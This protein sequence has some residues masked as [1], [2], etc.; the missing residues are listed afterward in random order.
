MAALMGPIDMSAIQSGRMPDH[1]GLGRPV[2]ARVSLH[3]VD[4]GSSHRRAR[5]MA[6][7]LND[8][9]WVN[10]RSADAILYSAEE[11]VKDR[12]EEE[13]EEGDAKHAGEHGDAHG[14]T[15]LGAD[16]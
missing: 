16:A 4:L 1:W 14:V 6:G 12:S 10:S 5:Q 2:R 7:D 3:V 15:H 13:A 9:R 11:H 8:L